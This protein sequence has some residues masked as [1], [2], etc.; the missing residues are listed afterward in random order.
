MAHSGPLKEVAQEVANAG[1][2]HAVLLGMGGSSLCPEV[3]RK[4]FGT[5][6]GF[7]ELHVLDSTDPAQ[8]AAIEHA[9]DLAHTLFI[10]SSKSG[11]TLEPNILLQ[12][13]FDAREDDASARRMR[14]AISSPSPIPTRRSTTSPSASGSVRCSSACRASAAAIRRSRTSAWSRRR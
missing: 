11:T 5:I 6:K 9:V 10:V 12:Y 8:I 7:P 4:T 1:V 2:S 14:A 13:F 3:M